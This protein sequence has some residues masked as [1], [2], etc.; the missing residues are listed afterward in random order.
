MNFSLKN[1]SGELFNLTGTVGKVELIST[2]TTAV[3]ES[4]N[5]SDKYTSDDAGDLSNFSQEIFVFDT[6]G[7]VKR[8]LRQ[9]RKHILTI[10]PTIW[11]PGLIM[12]TQSSSTRSK[13]LRSRATVSV[14]HK[15]DVTDSR[16]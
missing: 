11:R 5:V 9:G 14:F 1:Y 8:S 12:K 10:L 16:Q 4:W 15:V 2:F 7:A 3:S 6:W 13:L